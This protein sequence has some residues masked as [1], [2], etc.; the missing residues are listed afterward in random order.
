MQL[1]GPIDLQH[2]TLFVTVAEAECRD[3]HRRFPVHRQCLLEL[4]ACVGGV[5]GVTGS[6]FAGIVLPSK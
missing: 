2:V 6:N 1:K 4:C 3:L 5:R